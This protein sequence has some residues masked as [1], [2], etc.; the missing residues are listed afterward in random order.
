MALLPYTLVEPKGSLSP[1]VVDSPHSGRIYPI[2]FDFI[3]P[4]PLLR[5]AEDAYVDELIGGA[6]EAGATVIIAEFPRSMIDVN[7]AENDIDPAAIDGVW[8]EPLAPDEMTLA[9]FGL[10]RRLARNNIPLYRGPLSVAEI[11]RRIDVYYRPYHE[12]LRHR[13]AARITQFGSCYLL[14][15]H[16]MPDRTENGVPRSDFILG[17]RDGTSC[18]TALTKRAQRILEE[19]GY[20]VS[21][22]DPYKGREIAQRYGLMSQDTKQAA[23]ALQIEINRK[24]YMDETSVEKHDGFAQLRDNM[25]RFF[26]A[27]ASF[28]TAE[29]SEKLAAE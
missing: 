9:G 24:L 20:S 29:T 1:I 7:R 25:T 16:S 12:C 4:L 13:I 18:S 10:I 5:Q 21:L 17:D 26:H 3:C 15:V 2:D 22:N 19:M 23:Q 11:K 27:F 6:A 14:D 8:P 28:A